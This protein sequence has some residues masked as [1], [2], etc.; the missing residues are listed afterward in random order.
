[1]NACGRAPAPSRRGRPFRHGGLERL[2]PRW[3]LAADP[4]S[5]HP[6]PPALAVP[7]V[8]GTITFDPDS[9]GKISPSESATA[10][11]VSISGEVTA[12]PL[13]P[14]F[15][16]ANLNVRTLPGAPTVRVNDRLDS[17]HQFLVYRIP[18]DHMTTSVDVELHPYGPASTMLE[19]M[20]LADEAGRPL[21]T[22]PPPPPG[23]R[24]LWISLSPD[25]LRSLKQRG[26]ALY[27]MVAAPA[28]AFQ[29]GPTPGSG[30]SLPSNST[31]IASP[32][33]LGF[34][35]V[36]ERVSLASAASLSPADYSG[37]VVNVVT[38]GDRPDASAA[39]APAV[40]TSARMATVG[41][42]TNPTRVTSATTV[43]VPVATGSLPGRAVGPLGGILGTGDEETVVDR[44]DPTVFDLA[45][46][47]LPE[48][49]GPDE[50]AA[51]L[52]PA[53]VGAQTSDDVVVAVRGPGGFPLF[54]ASL[55]TEARPRPLSM[56][57]AIPVLA[58]AP[59]PVPSAGADTPA[60]E[61]MPHPRGVRRCLSS[62]PV[63]TAGCALI[64]HLNLPDLTDPLRRRLNAMRIVWRRSIAPAR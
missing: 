41:D 3:L 38:P 40:G 15:A 19:A 29:D 30:G 18:I 9:D 49:Q 63:L 28:A 13:T 21:A 8:V 50:A 55:Q 17:D 23:S 59:I 2:E 12:P 48:D 25:H 32:A 57:P 5:W 56:L 58:A 10:P 64:T 52:A 54:G 26:G 31:D 14:P 16:W 39:A 24:S 51:G 60:D 1:M 27:L 11:S 4:G 61:E 47:D 22:S 34:V 37:T 7:I 53:F 43:K 33:S 42:I 36:V 45:L 44:T 46:M 6:L 20:T 35:L 62:I